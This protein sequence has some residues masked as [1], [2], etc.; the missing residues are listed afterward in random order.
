[1]IVKSTESYYVAVLLNEKVIDISSCLKIFK[2]LD[3][4]KAKKISQTLGAI[5]FD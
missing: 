2:G 4:D 3:Q 5:K 1:M